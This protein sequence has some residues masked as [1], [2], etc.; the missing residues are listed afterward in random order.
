MFASFHN[1]RIVLVAVQDEAVYR[2][3]RYLSVLRRIGISTRYLR[4]GYRG[5]F[6]CVGYVGRRPSW[7]RQISHRRRRGPSVIRIRIPRYGGRYTS[8]FYRLSNGPTII[9]FSNKLL[10]II[11][12]QLCRSTATPKKTKKK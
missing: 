11:I 4:F 6:A 1:R 9:F 12:V 7:F 5:S 3:K 2:A 10:V 8:L